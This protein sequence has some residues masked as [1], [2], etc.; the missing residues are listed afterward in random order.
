MLDSGGNRESA[1]L[2]RRALEEFAREIDRRAFLR[3]ALE[4]GFG[5]FAG[6]ALGSSRIISVLAADGG[7]K[8]CSPLNN[9]YCGALGY[10]C[11]T[12]AAPGCPTGCRICE[13]SY[14]SHCGYPAGYWSVTGCGTCKNGTEYCTDCVCPS[15][16]SCAAGGCTCRSGCICCNCCTPQDIVAEL[17]RVTAERAKSAE[18]A[19]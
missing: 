9:T 4:V 11:S 17:T 2:T 1:S 8:S 14:C 7:C 3:R 12:S 19:A 10:P 15:N 6:A 16:A 18:R 13:N 5:L